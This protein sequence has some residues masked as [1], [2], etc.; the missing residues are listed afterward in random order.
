MCCQ[1][2]RQL[3]SLPFDN[4]EARRRHVMFLLETYKAQHLVGFFLRLSEALCRLISKGSSDHHIFEATHATKRSG[5]LKRPANAHAAD[6]VRSQ[7]RNFAAAEK[8]TPRITL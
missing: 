8:D 4:I 3:Q 2:P 5:E 1:C 6:L 7:T